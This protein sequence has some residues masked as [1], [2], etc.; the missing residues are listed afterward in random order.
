MYNIGS[1][2][3]HAHWHTVMDYSIGVDGKGAPVKPV[4]GTSFIYAGIVIL[5]RYSLK[6]LDAARLTNNIYEELSSDLIYAQ[7][8]ILEDI[9]LNSV[10]SSDI[11]HPI[12]ANTPEERKLIQQIQKVRLLINKFNTTSCR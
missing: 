10:V 7:R 8:E 4:F 12:S 5:L 6:G 11:I 3:V 1:Q 2:V 9:R